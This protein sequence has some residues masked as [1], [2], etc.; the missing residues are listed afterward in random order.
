MQTKLERLRR[1]IRELD[2]RYGMQDED[3]QRLE[4]ELRALETVAAAPMVE[5]RVRPSRK[6]AFETAAKQLYRASG[7]HSVH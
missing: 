3:V 2:S 7:V 1:I 6:F 5:R 4:R